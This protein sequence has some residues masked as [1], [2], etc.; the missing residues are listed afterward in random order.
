MENI[1]SYYERELAIQRAKVREFVER[2]PKPGELFSLLGERSS[3]AGVERLLQV[4]ALLSARIDRKLERAHEPF[5][6]DLRGILA[7]FYPRNIPSCSVAQVD[8]AGGR[9]IDTIQHDTEL[10]A[11]A[12][13]G[14]GFRTIYDAAVSP[15][16]S[17][18]GSWRA[19]K[20]QPSSVCLSASD[21]RSR[22]WSTPRSQRSLSKK[23]P[24]HPSAYSSM[25][26]APHAA[27]QYAMF[28]PTVCTCV[29]SE[30]QWPQLQALRCAQVGFVKEEAFLLTPRLQE[31]SLRLLMEYFAFPHKL[32]VTDID[33]K[34]VLAACPAGT[35][36]L[37]LHLLQLHMH[38]TAMPQ[39][40][41][42][43][44]ATALRLGCAPVVNMFSRATMPIRLRKVRGAYP[45]SI[46]PTSGAKAILYSIDAMK[47]KQGA[48]D[49]STA[50]DMNWFYIKRYETQP[51][52][53]FE[54]A[55]PT[56]GNS[57]TV[58]FVNR[59][60]EPLKLG[61]GTVP[62]QVTCTNGNAPCSMSIGCGDGD[63]AGQS[64]IGGTPI[65]MLC[66]PSM[67][68]LIA[69]EAEVQ[70][71]ERVFAHYL[72]AALPAAINIVN[73]RGKSRTVC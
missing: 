13:P 54:L 33:L 48:D 35:W 28:V 57:D 64:V 11:K 3:D 62:A 46:Q 15:S 66:E 32:N 16:R 70:V 23:R 36:R 50:I 39:L 40:L 49:G 68:L 42:T 34:A 14:F 45:A 25:P 72:V 63:M 20:R 6:N 9:A 12:A 67:P 55:N 60:Y 51:C 4:A 29:Q 59:V 58:S 2:Y 37:A 30:Q 44:P 69:D 65:R 52:W 8:Y 19:P 73:D 43:L 27:L 47:L 1:L 38:A 41:R 21:A 26:M 17:P 22:S 7:P 56:V 31:E 71:R 5:T 18:S 53:T 10:Q 24:V 61:E